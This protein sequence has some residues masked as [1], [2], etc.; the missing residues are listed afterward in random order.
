MTVALEATSTES[1]PTSSSAPSSGSSIMFGVTLTLAML[2]IWAICANVF[3]TNLVESKHA[4]FDKVLHMPNAD[5]ASK[6]VT[7]LNDYRRDIESG[8]QMLGNAT[9]YDKEVVSRELK[10][11][12]D[13]ILTK[14]AH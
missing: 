5:L 13:L 9:G 2:V 12:N 3:V 7:E 10:R 14:T 1:K 11:V 4:T 8:S 6:S